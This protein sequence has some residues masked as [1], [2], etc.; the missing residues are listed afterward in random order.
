MTKVSISGFIKKMKMLTFFRSSSSNE[1]IENMKIPLARGNS[2]DAVT[3]KVI[4]ECFDTTETSTFSELK[5]CVFSETGSVGVEKSAC[6]T[7][8][9][10]NEFGRGD[11]RS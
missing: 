5:F 11:L 2:R 10:D 1:V 6:V 8:R 9:F 3:F 4:I 7:K